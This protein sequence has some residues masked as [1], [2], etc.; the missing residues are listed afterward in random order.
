MPF[1]AWRR[2]Q[3]PPTHE[4][5]I[6][7]NHL[8]YRRAALTA[9]SLL[10]LLS[11]G[12]SQTLPRLDGPLSLARAIELARQNNPAVSVSAADAKAA[13]EATRAAKARRLPTISANGFA[14]LGSYGSIYGSAP[15]V[16]PAYSL[17]VPSG[18]VLDANLMLMAPLSTGGSL[19]AM[20]ESA[21]SQQAAATFEL[22]ETRAD[23]ALGTVDAYLRA[24]LATANARVA[25]SRAAAA[26]ELVRTTRA[27][28]EAGKGIAASV[29][30]AAA[31]LSA[32]RRA[33]ST[34][35][36]EREKAVLEL[37][38]TLGIDLDSDVSLADELSEGEGEAPVAAGSQ[39]GLLLAA[40]AR[41]SAAAAE[42]RVAEGATR[43]QLYGVAMADA[44]KPSTMS[45]AS[46]G[47]VLSVPV[48]NGGALRAE[49][50]RAR[51]LRE[52]AAASLRQAELTVGREIREAA[53]DRATAASNLRSARDSVEAAQAAYDVTALRVSAGKGILVEQLDALQALTSA[54][55]DLARAL[56]D[57]AIALA[58]QRRAAGLDLLGEKR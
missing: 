51:A 25:E 55:A 10:T 29:Q 40:K 49:V 52:R 43:P 5:P 37:K 20:V 58:R 19:G 24:Q 12:I 22:S 57:S 26:S 16:E 18:A 17:L 41:L 6:S 8:T 35:Q 38:A 45:G 4:D 2:G 1:A 56:Y 39:R 7:T 32:A 30:R 11:Q 42:V 28:F 48:F 50:A 23:A 31:E 44:G 9:L 54:R 3:R 47:L 34:A 36:G 33:V 53:V 15:R 21:R 27:Q 46:L 14:T 13:A